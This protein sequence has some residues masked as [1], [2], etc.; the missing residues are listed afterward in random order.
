MAEK[1]NVPAAP[2]FEGMPRDFAG[3]WRQEYVK[4]LKQAEV[5][6]PGDE[7]EQRAV[8]TREA[9]RLLAVDEPESY[10]EAM[11]IEEWKCL[12]RKPFGNE[13]KLVTINGRKYSF[14]IP[15]EKPKQAERPK[16][17]EKPSAAKGGEGAGGSQGAT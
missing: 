9:N 12:H 8:A 13:L 3:R 14:P 16:E 6:Y 5:N 7:T 1:T 15:E 10:E 4:A 2:Y 17:I 11:A